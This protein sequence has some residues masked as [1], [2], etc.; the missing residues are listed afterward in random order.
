[1]FPRSRGFALCSICWA[2]GSI[3]LFWSGTGWAA[4]AKTLDERFRQVE[5]MSELDRVRLQRNIAEF[6]KLTPDQQAHYRDLHSKLD[7]NKS[8]GGQ[9]SNL[10]QE[11]SAWLTTLTPSQRDELNNATAT[12]QK[13][14]LVRQFKEAQEY[15]PEP[16]PADVAD[17][18][19]VDL[20][21]FRRNMIGGPPLKGSE[22]IAVMNAINKELHGG[23][24]QKKPEGESTLKYYVEL[25]K[26]SIEKSPDGPRS[27]PHESL[28]KTLEQI[29]G[30]KEHLKRRPDG[31]RVA[32]VRLIMGSLANMAFEGF[33]PP[34]EQ[35]RDAVF[36]KLSPEKQAEINKHPEAGRR[37]LEWMYFQ[38]RGDDMPQRMQEFRH[39]MDKFSVELGVSLGPPSNGGEGFRHGQGPGGQR[40][41]QDGRPFPDGGRPGDPPRGRNDQDRPRGRPND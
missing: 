2:L 5:K 34:T 1:M 41:P 30:M 19:A 9:L 23:V 40:R 29:P 33:K 10:L 20:P 14:D 4:D 6:K 21:I 36:N 37:M 39:Q 38:Q 15:R 8:T 7:E 24:E 16:S 11:Y 32:L 17:G 35:D 13:L 22:L 28:Q 3:C 27:W 31:G 26:S 12:A 18:P 25:L